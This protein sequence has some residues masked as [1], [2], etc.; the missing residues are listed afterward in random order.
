MIANTFF[1]AGFIEAWGRGIEKIQASCELAGNQMP[2]YDVRRTEITVRFKSLNVAQDVA[3]DVAQG[4]TLEE[5]ILSEI[6]KN[7]KVT[8]EQIAKIAKVNKKTVERKLKQMKN[9]YYQGRGFSGH[10]IVTD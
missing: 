3:Q 8:R 2:E 7:N 4:K 5:I 1:R 9:V 6:K 10:W